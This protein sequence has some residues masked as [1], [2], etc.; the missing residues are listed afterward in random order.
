MTMNDTQRKEEVD[1]SVKPDDQVIRA[2]PLPKAKV[3]VV[4]LVMFA[5]QYGVLLIFPFLPFMISDF[6]PH[7]DRTEIGKKAGF[8]GSAY[9]IGSF[10]GS[11]MW[12]W[13]ADVIGRRPAM[14]LSITGTI[15]SFTLFG[16]SENFAWAV[17]VRLLLGLL[18]GIMGISKTYLSEICDNTNQAKGFALMAT[19]NGFARLIGSLTG[20]FLARPASKYP[21]FDVPFFCQFPYF[22]PCM[23]GVAVSMISLVVA[24]LFL[25]E[26]LK[27]KT[28]L[29][30]DT[31]MV[32]SDAVSITTSEEVTSEKGEH[33]KPLL[34][35]HV[36]RRDKKLNTLVMRFRSKLTTVAKLMKDRR[37]FLT[38]TIYAEMG[39][40]VIIIYELFPLLMV[41]SHSDGGYDMDDNEIGLFLSIAAFIQIFYLALVYPQVAKLLGY[42]HSF[43]LG[44][45]VFGIGCVLLPLANQISGPIQTSQSNHSNFTHN[46]TQLT[47]Y[48]GNQVYFNNHLWTFAT[49]YGNNFTSGYH[50]DVSKH[51]DCNS[52]DCNTEISLVN[53][54]TNN[55]CRDSHLESSVGI[56]SIGRIPWRVWLTISWI[57]GMI[58]IGRLTSFTSI[59]VMVGNSALDTVGHSIITSYMTSSH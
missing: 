57:L 20:G 58:T 36:C 9:Y 5:D 11:L 18:D 24:I 26:T 49:L 2:T 47:V 46:A 37:V 7:L 10:A 45:I 55:S 56:N 39:F 15:I 16:F 22:L 25:N 33:L 3:A 21:F 54:L 31:S 4:C 50:G 23:V 52:M 14:L 35:S 41:T 38:T 1:G 48:S 59:C 43:R 6:F 29:E 51:L 34:G 44:V 28:P 27:K 13:L 17:C 8:L 12:G 32:T 19:M 30:D 40:I 42:R 53:N